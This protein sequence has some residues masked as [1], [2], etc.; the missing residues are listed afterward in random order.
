MFDINRVYTKT[1]GNGISVNAALFRGN[2]NLDLIRILAALMVI[3]GHSFALSLNQ[4]LTEPF[5]YVFPFTYSGSIA[6]KIFFFISGLLVTNSMIK[7]DSI[8]NYIISRAFRIY[9]AFA[10]TII[11]TGLIIGPIAFN[12]EAAQYFNEHGFIVYITHSLLFNTQYFINGLFSGNN[13]SG[14]LNG[15]LWTI[16]IE[17]SAYCLVMSLYIFNCFRN[18]VLANLIC[19]LI[20]IIPLTNIEGLNFIVDRSSEAFLLP[21]CFALGALYAIN[22]NEINVSLKT[23]LAFF[24]IY[25]TSYSENLSHFAFYAG[26]CT[27]VL[28]ISTL[29]FFK[30]IKIKY[31]ISYGIYLWG[32]PI[33]QLLSYF[34]KLDTLMLILFSA[35]L[36]VIAGCLSFILIERPAMRI[37]KMIAQRLH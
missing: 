33:Q 26:V 28:Y 23:P 2:N 18:R 1:I 31:D 21:S 34:Y 22:K 17:V 6:V 12:G 11:I 10:V 32:F 15:S 14:S 8:R 4:T 5:S 25:K 27:S 29:E 13:D 7:S 36:A 24:I 35:V 37:G 16:A 30:S 20:I 19:L 3:F 9:P